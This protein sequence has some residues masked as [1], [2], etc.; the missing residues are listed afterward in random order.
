MRDGRISRHRLSSNP[1]PSLDFYTQQSSIAY[2]GGDDGRQVAW[3][4][5]TMAS[6]SHHRPLSS[7]T[8]ARDWVPSSPPTAS[9][10]AA[11][12]QEDYANHELQRVY[13]IVLAAERK[14]PTLP[15]AN[16]NATTALFS[17]YVDLLSEVDIDPDSDRKISKLLF[18]IG[19]LKYGNTLRTS[20]DAVM[21]R[22]GITTIIDGDDDDDND[23]DGGGGGGGGDNGRGNNN[24]YDNNDFENPTLNS[25]RITFSSRSDQSD[26]FIYDDEPTGPYTEDDTRHEDDDDGHGEDSDDTSPP[27]KTHPGRDSLDSGRS[28][29]LE[30]ETALEKSALAFERHRDKFAA[31]SH[32]QKW[33]SRSSYIRTTTE[34]IH[35]AR[36]ADVQESVEPV[37]A[38][39]NET[40]F[41]VHEAPL[42]QLPPNV[43]SERLETIARRAHQIMAAKKAL[44]GWRQCTSKQNERRE[45]EQHIEGLGDDSQLARLATRAHVTLMKS[46]A[47]TQWF[48]RAS[49]EEEKARVAA[50]VHEMGLKSRA[51]G[52]RPK[53]DTLAQALRER[54]QAGRTAESSAEPPE[55]PESSEVPP[56]PVVEPPPEPPVRPPSPPVRPPPPPVVEPDVPIQTIE[57]EPDEPE[58]DEMALLARRH[59]LRMRFFR[60]WEDYTRLHTQKVREHVLR[61][62][63]D[64]WHERSVDLSEKVGA[65]SHQRHGNTARTTLRAWTDQVENADKKRNAAAVAEKKF[66]IDGALKPWLAA[67]REGRR[68]QDEQW[69]KFWEWYRTPDRGMALERAAVLFHEDRKLRDTVA[70]WRPLAAEAEQARD[71]RQQWAERG[72]FYRRMSSAVRAWKA[73]AREK[74]VQ[75]SMEREALETWRTRCDEDTPHHRQMQTYAERADFFYRVTAVMPIWRAATKRAVEHSQRLGYYGDRADFYYST[76]EALLAWRSLAKRKRKERLREAHLEVRRRVKKGMGAYCIAQWRAQLQPTYDHFESMNAALAQVTAE[77]QLEATA[78]AFDT[79]R[80]QA[81][82]KAQMNSI[83]GVVVQQKALDGWRHQHAQRQDLRVEANDFWQGRNMS[84]ALKEWNLNSMQ[85]SSRRHTVQH[86]RERADRRQLRR[87]FEDWCKRNNEKRASVHRP[88]VPLKSIETPV[89]EGTPQQASRQFRT[90]LFSSWRAASRGPTPQIAEDEEEEEEEETA[91]DAEEPYEPTPGRPQLL[92]GSFGA[93]TTTPLAPVP[94]RPVWPGRDSVLGGSVMEGRA[95]RTGRNRR[96]LRVSWAN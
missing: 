9:S 82:E 93:E 30:P 42:H 14:L 51:F 33:Q 11:I 83:S 54:M 89:V 78:E 23:D 6:G 5:F 32:F 7:N 10:F 27:Q 22:M 52:V 62:T 57:E 87:G 37:F 46:R 67:A 68:L 70:A 73:K 79:W 15:R 1:L 66:R 81:Q 21:G 60:A 75:K 19:S 63:V 91:K 86:V 94:S 72:D 4:T 18:L 56:A 29:D 74:A 65:F 41:L 49:E 47:F 61:S 69:Q 76:R 17:V 35:E 71:S 31:W 44:A 59:I 48:N 25:P 77:R 53:L 84:R 39:W 43:Y 55:Q 88:E 92:L 34:Q 26:D 13:S 58:D 64:P 50:K 24:N 20:F 28:A 2:S 85:V 90:S 40:V 80:A 45:D 96:N 8:D 36:E 3:S 95:P 12:A 16:R 38:A